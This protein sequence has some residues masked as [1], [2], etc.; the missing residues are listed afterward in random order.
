MIW[1]MLGLYPVVTQPVY[2]LLS[3]WFSDMTL[4]VGGDKTLRITAQHL[5]ETSYFVQSATVNVQAWNQS[6]ISHSDI[7]GGQGQHNRICIG[8]PKD[9]M[10]CW[11]SSTKPGP[12]CIVADHLCNRSSNEGI[13]ATSARPK[14]CS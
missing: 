1:N 13:T 4:G 8:Q 6:W 12:P 10:G 2:L 3:P 5:S 7:V 9:S 14:D 11:I